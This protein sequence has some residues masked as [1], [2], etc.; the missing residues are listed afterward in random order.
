MLISLVDFVKDLRHKFSH[1]EK[2]AK[3]LSIFVNQEYSS[4]DKRNITRKFPDKEVQVDRLSATDNF[5]INTFYVI[6][7][8]L[9]A[10]LQKRSEA[11]NHIVYLF[12]FLIQFLFI[13]SAELETKA[14]NLIEVYS[15][16]LQNYLLLELKQFIPCLKL[17]P[18]GFFF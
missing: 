14:T 7:D 13:K 4:S 8:K 5:R 1:I 3:Q 9:V 6:I 2:E 10:E 15:D 16:D 11:Y 17:Q 18:K 12:S